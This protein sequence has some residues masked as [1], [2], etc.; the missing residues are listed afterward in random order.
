VSLNVLGGA[1]AGALALAAGYAVAR[2]TGLTRIDLAE[3]LAPG[4]PTLGRIA[5]VAAGTGACLP[6]AWLGSPGPALL[7]GAAAGAVAA[8]TVER[9]SD[10]VLAVAAH[11]LAGLVAASIR[12][13]MRAPR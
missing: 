4:R 13:A 3:R 11:A 10:R 5:Q 2:R 1:V 9:R 7:A 12:R 6:A 8:T